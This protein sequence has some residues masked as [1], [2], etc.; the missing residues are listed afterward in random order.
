MVIT[1]ITSESILFEELGI[2]LEAGRST[3]TED[4]NSEYLLNRTSSELISAYYANEIRFSDNVGNIID[5]ISLITRILTGN[6]SSADVSSQGASAL[7]ASSLEELNK[8]TK[9]DIVSDE[10]YY[11]NRKIHLIKGQTYKIQFKGF[12]KTIYVQTEEANLV[13][14]LDNP[15]MSGMEIDSFSETTFDTDYKIK[16]LTLK[17]FARESSSFNLFCD[18]IYRTTD[19][20]TKTQFISE[21]EAKSDISIDYDEYDYGI[22]F[23]IDLQDNFDFGENVIVDSESMYPI[24]VNNDN[25]E[26][27]RSRLLSDDMHFECG[28]IL[29]FTEEEEFTVTAWFKPSSTDNAYILDNSEQFSIK[30]D[31]GSL[32]ASARG[33]WTLVSDA[34][35]IDKWY[36]ISLVVGVESLNV[37]LDGALIQSLVIG[38][39]PPRLYSFNIA[40]DI[41]N[42]YTFKG[43]LG[44]IRVYDYAMS[45]GMVGF[46]VLNEN[47]MV[48]DSLGDTHEAG[49]LANYYNITNY[50]NQYPKNHFEYSILEKEFGTFENLIGSQEIQVLDSTGLDIPASDYYL[51]IIS[52]ILNIEVTGH[53]WFSIDGG[54]AVEFL[55]DDSEVIGWYDAHDETLTDVRAVKMFLKAGT[56]RLKYRHQEILGTSSFHLHWKIPGSDIFT[57]IPEGNIFRKLEKKSWTG[58]FWIYENTVSGGTIIENLTDRPKELSLG[59]KDVLDFKGNDYLSLGNISDTIYSPV[60][61]VSFWFKYISDYSYIVCSGGG[62]AWDHHFSVSTS[63]RKLHMSLYNKDSVSRKRLAYGKWYRIDVMSDGVNCRTFINAKEETSMKVSYV[64]DDSIE[65][66]SPRVVFNR[67]GDLSKPSWMEGEFSLGSFVFSTSLLSKN[68]IESYYTNEKANYA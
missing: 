15:R 46:A 19:G 57:E 61:R 65:F 31:G 50:Q 26:F 24:S 17:F 59:S 25:E 2:R 22:I 58:L 38:Y 33:V 28:N 4:I 14:Y 3:M 41:N 12:M 68:E 45:K 34:I 48:K 1:N 44:L 10:Y 47:P 49:L 36:N 9:D 64:R 40:S 30:I 63:R 16:D 39:I 55:L 42:A 5:D 8:V 37:Y 60:F 35:I 53:Y 52:G 13:G 23:S 18:G 20:K 56:Y 51:T 67:L 29:S 66:T 54:D 62:P 32:Y 11:F 21:L 6:S 27:H 43:E 7:T